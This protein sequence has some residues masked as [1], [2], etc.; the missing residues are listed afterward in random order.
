VGGNFMAV[1]TS[2]FLA[3]FFSQN[4]QRFHKQFSLSIVK[5]HRSYAMKNSKKTTSGHKENTDF[6][7]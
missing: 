4:W 2:G 3:N 7:S 1:N 5:Y 6:T